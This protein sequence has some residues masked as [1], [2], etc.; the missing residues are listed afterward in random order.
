MKLIKYRFSFT[1]FMQNQSPN[2]HKIKD[3]VRKGA[4]DGGEDEAD[5]TKEQSTA[6]KTLWN[7]FNFV[8][9]IKH[10]QGTEQG[11]YLQDL[12]SEDVDPEVYA[13]YFPER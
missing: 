12:A 10:N 1:F 11:M 4:E 8:Q 7:K 13:L 9:N 5:M 6:R 3:L 2:E